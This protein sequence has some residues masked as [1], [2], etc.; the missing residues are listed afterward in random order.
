MFT[1]LTSTESWELIIIFK[2]TSPSGGEE[3]TEITLNKYVIN[4]DKA[5][6]DLLNEKQKFETIIK[7][8]DKE[9]AELANNVV[10]QKNKITYLESNNN[11]KQQ[12]IITNENEI[13]KLNEIIKS[14]EDSNLP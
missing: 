12:T 5:I 8:K 6:N 10:N 4:Q 9:I 1:S 7:K 11:S 14:H 13:K 2:L 3:I